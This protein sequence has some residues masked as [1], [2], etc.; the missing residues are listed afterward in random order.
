MVLV[1]GVDVPLIELLLV[2]GVIIFLLLIEAV[3]V[4]GILVK[5]LQKTKQL[6]ALTV[7]LSESLLKLKEGMMR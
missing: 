6:S 1:F 7:Q 4:I 3:V 5:Q 2:F